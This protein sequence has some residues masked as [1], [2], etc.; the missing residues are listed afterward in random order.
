MS[1]PVWASPVEGGVQLQIY[2]N[3]RSSRTESAGEYGDRL[4]IQIASPPVDGEA[5]EALL[6]FL[7]DTFGCASRDLRIVRG[8]RGK[9]KTVELRGIT[10]ADVNGAGLA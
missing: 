7:A 2:A 4:K 8:H 3:P 6:E 1:S 9:R 10:L 5:N